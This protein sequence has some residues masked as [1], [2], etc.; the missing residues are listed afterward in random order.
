LGPPSW[1]KLGFGT[2]FLDVD[3][4]GSLDI[5]VTNGHVSRN[6]DEDGNPDNTFRQQAQLFLNDGRGRFQHVSGV[7]GPYFQERHVGRGLAAGDYDNDGHMD[8]AFNHSGEP[9]VL[10]HNETKTPYHWIRLELQGTQSNR[11]AVGARVTIQVG[12]RRIVRHRKGGG[13]YLSSSDPRLLVGIGAANMVD[14]IEI[15]W[16]SG[17]VQRTGSLEGDR[18]Y[19][20]IEGED[21]PRPRSR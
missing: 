11:D 2:C 14:Q 19:I 17:R 8:L 10:L 15:R 7:A 6:V 9:A 21:E 20:I 3:R 12:N 18:G 1:W 13:S 5:V 16:P 4:D